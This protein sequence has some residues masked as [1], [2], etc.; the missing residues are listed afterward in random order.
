MKKKHEDDSASAQMDLIETMT[1]DDGFNKLYNS[2]GAKNTIK[3]ETL[4]DVVVI[5]LI[6][7]C[8]L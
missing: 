7:M 5:C 2:L 6:K 3:D 1:K 8:C 4:P